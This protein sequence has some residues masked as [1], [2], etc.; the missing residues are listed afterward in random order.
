MAA[1]DPAG[2][3]I[4]VRRPAGFADLYEGYSLIGKK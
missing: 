1:N 4:R 3:A 2:A